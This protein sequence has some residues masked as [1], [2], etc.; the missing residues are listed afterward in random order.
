MLILQTRYE[1]SP[2]P[3]VYLFRAVNL[4]VSID[5]IFTTDA[6]LYR[7]AYGP[8]KAVPATDHSDATV[9]ADS[10]RSLFEKTDSLPKNVCLGRA[11]KVF[12]KLYRVW[13]IPVFHWFSLTR[14][15]A[16]SKCVSTFPQSVVKQHCASIALRF[17]ENRNRVEENDAKM[18]VNTKSGQRLTWESVG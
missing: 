2:G 12:Q 7:A 11:C 14:S 8:T 9:F 16:S 15:T 4:R 10:P 3:K 13:R 5:A 6:K 1:K 17:T 18:C